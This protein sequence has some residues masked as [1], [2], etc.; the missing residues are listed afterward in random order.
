MRKGGK[1]KTLW[2]GTCNLAL[3]KDQRVPIT[4]QWN[5][6]S[7]SFDKLNCANYNHMAIH[8][9]ERTRDPRCRLLQI[10][11]ALHRAPSRTKTLFISLD[12]SWLSRN[13]RSEKWHP[14]RPPSPRNPQPR[15]P[16]VGWEIGQM[17]KSKKFAPSGDLG[18]RGSNQTL[19]LRKL[20]A[21]W[22]LA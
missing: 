7:Q 5:E 1:R 13:A 15:H 6:L 17:R 14:N 3:K 19:Y 12:L 4:P 22:N 16:L 20:T 10:W 11:F 18:W 2:W 8:T 9:L 21:K